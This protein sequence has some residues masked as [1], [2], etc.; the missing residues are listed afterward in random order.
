MTKKKGKKTIIWVVILLLIAAVGYFMLST[1]SSRAGAYLTAESYTGNIS[2]TFSFTG[3]TESLHEQAIAAPVAATVKEVYI[4]ANDTV[5]ADAKLMKLDDG[6]I[7]RAGIAGEIVRLNVQK[8]DV[9]SVGQELVKVMTVDKLQVRIA[10]DEYDVAAITLGKHVDVTINALDVTCDGVIVSFDK[11]ASTSSQL[12]SYA[13]V[14]TLDA[15]ENALPGMQ[16]EVKMLNQSAQGVVL[17]NM[18]A[19]QFD[20]Q[21]KAYVLTRGTSEEYAT[22]YIETGISDGSFIEVTSGLKSGATVYYKPTATEASM[23]MGGMGGM[24][25]GMRNGQ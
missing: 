2:T 10:I 15:P 13:A 5:K 21:N 1:Q 8:D 20:A 11:D 18:D 9:V 23:M 3:N 14:I 19:V 24:G 12:S 17:L 25:G 16:V 4:S 7:I 22:Q 6:T